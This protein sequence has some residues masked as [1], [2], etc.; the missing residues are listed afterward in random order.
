VPEDHGDMLQ[1]SLPIDFGANFEVNIFYYYFLPGLA[2]THKLFFFTLL[3]LKNLEKRAYLS[4]QFL[5]LVNNI[6]L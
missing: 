3:I 1:F 5:I 4:S 6:R 2:I